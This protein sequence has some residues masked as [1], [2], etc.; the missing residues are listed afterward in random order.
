MRFYLFRHY[1]RIED[2]KI[3]FNVYTRDTSKYFFL[4]QVFFYHSSS[5]ANRVRIV[6][7]KNSILEYLG[8]IIYLM[9][10]NL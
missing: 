4:T 2:V 8:Y 10:W 5:T 3:I 9:T 7:I 6:V 1:L